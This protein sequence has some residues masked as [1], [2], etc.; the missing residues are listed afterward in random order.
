MNGQSMNDELG[1]MWN[2]EIM[3]YFKVLFRDLPV[4]TEGNSR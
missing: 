1:D 4:G 3:A 2:E